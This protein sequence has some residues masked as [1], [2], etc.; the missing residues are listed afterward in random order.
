MNNAAS[1]RKS[2]TTSACYY[3]YAHRYTPTHVL[4]LGSQVSLSVF[5]QFPLFV[6]AMQLPSLMV[7]AKGDY[8][9][10]HGTL[11]FSEN[12]TGWQTL[13][14]SGFLVVAWA[15]SLTSNLQS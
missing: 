14:A 2:L 1:F 9:Y 13:G 10:L 12:L 4:A 7:R 3:K 8:N 11:F 15:C 6:G 5:V